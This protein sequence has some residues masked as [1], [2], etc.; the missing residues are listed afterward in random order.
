VG[1]VKF[2]TSTRR[3]TFIRAWRKH[4]NLRLEDVAERVG[5]TIGAL[6]QLERGEV[7]YTQPMVEAL[8]EVMSCEPA[9]LI[10]RPPETETPITQVWS[11]IPI[12][13][14]DRALAVLQ[15]FTKPTDKPD[16]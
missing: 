14:R 10:S 1:K 3:P 2:N 15:A 13:D 11:Q 6:S 12:P 16:L 7:A 4:R 8:A 9:D 5:V